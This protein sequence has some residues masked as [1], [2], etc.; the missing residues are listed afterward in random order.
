MKGGEIIGS[1]NVLPSRFESLRIKE[2]P[3]VIFL[4]ERRVSVS[5]ESSFSPVTILSLTS[6]V[7]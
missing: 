5:I 1:V 2:T 3:E 4:L 6:P 7:S